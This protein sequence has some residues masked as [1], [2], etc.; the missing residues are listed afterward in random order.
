MPLMRLKEVN[1]YYE[2]TGVGKQTL[3]F[4]HGFTCDHSDWHFQVQRLSDAYQV[5]TCDLRGHGQSTGDSPGCTIETLARDIGTL[6]NVLS[7]REVVLIGHSMGCRVVLE[8]YLRNPQLVAGIILVDGSLMGKGNAKDAQET[9]RRSIEKI[10]YAEYAR[11]NFANMFFGNYDV[12]LKNRI[13]ERAL[14]LNPE[15]GTSL[16]ISFPGWD[17]AK[18]ETA[19]SELKVPLLVVQS[20][21]INASSERFS[22]KR[23]DTTSWL[24]LVRGL[25]PAARI[26]IISGYG[27]FVMLEAPDA[28]SELIDSFAAKL[29]KS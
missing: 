20:T 17:A 10:G 23:G 24:E 3:F 25:V 2:F 14:R 21:G 22:L 26:E 6:L 4:V 18:M 11:R 28:T 13:I 5:V 8:T 19:L 27:H 12:A 15:F 16:R 7:L 1:I 9:A 29:R